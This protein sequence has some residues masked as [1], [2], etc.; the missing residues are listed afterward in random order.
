MWELGLS[1]KA[2]EQPQN[3]LVLVASSTC[4]SSPI[5]VS[6]FSAMHPASLSYSQ[7][8][9]AHTRR[10]PCLWA[11]SQPAHHQLCSTHTRREP[12]PHIVEPFL[13]M[14]PCILSCPLSYPQTT[15]DSLL[16]SEVPIPTPIP[17][18]VHRYMQSAEASF[19]ESNL[20]Q[21]ASLW[22]GPPG[23]CRREG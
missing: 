16:H 22:E 14:L 19:P 20:R 18:T 21:A 4:T 13:C 23:S 9:S 2:V 8:S 15:S 3:I 10:E 6:Y 1:P 12:F 7:L 17:C 11:Q 5:T